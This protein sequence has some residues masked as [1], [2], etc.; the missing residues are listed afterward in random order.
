MTRQEL[1]RLA[2]E[3]DCL[4]PQHYG[5]QWVDK[6]NRLAELIKEHVKKEMKAKLQE[7][8]DK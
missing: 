7:W 4:D 6:L 3:A 2:H 1:I 8:S 5:S